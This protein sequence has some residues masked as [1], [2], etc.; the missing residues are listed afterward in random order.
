MKSLKIGKIKLKNPLFLAPMLDVTDIAYRE[1]CREAGASMAYTEMIVIDALLHENPKTQAM[2]KTSKK[3]RPI[4]IQITGDDLEKFK[5]AIP[6]FKKYDLVDINC[7]CPSSR[8]QSNEAGSFLLKTPEKIAAIIKL[9][10]SHSLIVTAK[11][12]LGFD[13]NNVL[14]IAKAIEEAGADAI[15][16]HARLA[17]HDNKIPADWKWIKKVKEAISI[18]VI[19]NGDV[20]KPED[21]K[22]MLELC[23]GVMIGRAAIGNPLIFKQTLDYLKT[24][25]YKSTNLSENLKYFKRYLKLARKY[26]I[27]D[28]TK[29][30]YIGSKFLR[31]ANN[32]AA[33]RNRLMSLK[34]Y[35]EINDFINTIKQQ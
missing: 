32:A 7:G 27:I 8:I 18:P 20:F 12:R 2:A 19:G 17:I 34:T 28:I 13:N 25:K 1:I 24:G 29:I 11:I 14:A 10:K 5:E 6:L 23:D 33:M 26:K 30:K 4:G 21:A 3:D 35:E 16:I 15:T 9:L 22:R 31:G